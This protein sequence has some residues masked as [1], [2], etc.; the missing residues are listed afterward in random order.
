MARNVPSLPMDAIA[1]ACRRSGVKELALFGSAVRDD[2]R[3]ASD[4]D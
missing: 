1:E 3:H 4:L 2:F